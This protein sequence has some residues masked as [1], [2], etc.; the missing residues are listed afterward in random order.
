M[1]IA[2]HIWSGNTSPDSDKLHQ[3]SSLA[4]PYC[5]K[6]MQTH[7]IEYEITTCY[8]VVCKQKRPITGEFIVHPNYLAGRLLIFSGWKDQKL[9][10][11]KERAQQKGILWALMIFTFGSNWSSTKLA[12][13]CIYEMFSGNQ[14]LAMKLWSQEVILNNVKYNLCQINEL[15][16]TDSS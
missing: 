10:L 3:W 2:N 11:A 13:M 15:P 9:G 12:G 5:E 4:A 14:K 8:F 16:L 1:T 6:L 7:I